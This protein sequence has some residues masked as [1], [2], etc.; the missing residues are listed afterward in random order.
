MEQPTTPPVRVSQVVVGV[1]GSACSWAAVDW[2]AG[3]ARSSGARLQ[4]LRA[5]GRDQVHDP[6]APV[7]GDLTSVAR[8][9]EAAGVNAT[10][11]VVDGEPAHVLV[12]L[13]AEADLLVLGAWGRRRREGLLLGE[14]A[15]HC[16]RHS[17]C[18][19]VLVPHR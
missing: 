19:L 17:R 16:A 18:P 11:R 3:I 2:A 8:K 5:V 4:L 6:G 14:V 12:G 9:L 7:N 1:D 15:Q 13:S 10:A